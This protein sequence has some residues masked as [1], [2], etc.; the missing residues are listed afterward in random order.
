METLE[1]LELLK[2]KKIF[3]QVLK[4]LFK[5]SDLLKKRLSTK[6]ELSTKLIRQSNII[7]DD[8]YHITKFKTPTFYLFENEIIH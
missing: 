2:Y 6:K 8:E 1:T 4:L 7:I 3:R 5:S